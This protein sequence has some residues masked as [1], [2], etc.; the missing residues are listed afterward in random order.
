MRKLQVKKPIEMLEEQRELLKRF[1]MPDFE[2][3]EEELNCQVFSNFKIR[4]YEPNGRYR[5]VIV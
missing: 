3:D 1:N 2:L 4:R 5:R